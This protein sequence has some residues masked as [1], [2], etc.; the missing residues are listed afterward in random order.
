MLICGR[1]PER[2]QLAKDA[3]QTEFGE[4]AEVPSWLQC[5]GT[6]D[7]CIMCPAKVPSAAGIYLRAY[8]SA[9][10]YGRCSESLVTFHPP[11]R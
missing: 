11:I 1:N 8:V 5:R 9:S 4:D 10:S 7:S 6:H 2:L 3:L